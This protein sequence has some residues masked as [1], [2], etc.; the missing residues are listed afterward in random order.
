[1]NIPVNPAANTEQNKAGAKENDDVQPIILS[2]LTGRDTEVDLLLDRWEQ[3]REGMGQVVLITG[4]A[5]LGKSRLVATIKQTVL[6]ESGCSSNDEESPARRYSSPVIEWRCSERFQSTGL[7]PFANCLQ[8]LLAFTSVETTES[9]FDRLAQY[10][11]ECGL[12]RREVVALFAKLLFLP[13]DERFSTGG[14]S[15]VRERE[16]TFRA[17]REWLKACS[18]RRPILFVIEDLHWFDASSLEF[19]QQ[20]VAEG[21]HESILTVL[22]FR[23]EFKTPW[24]ALAHQTSL[25]LNRLTRRQFAELMRKSAGGALPD[26]LM[27]QIYQRT[28]GVPLLV[29]E[30]TRMARESAIFDP[31]RGREMPATLQQLLMARLDRISSNREVAHFAAT[32]GREF[33]YE[34]L[35]AVV[36]VDEP[37]LQAELAKLAGAEILFSKGEPPRCAYLFK[38]ALLEEALR[39]ALESAQRR[40]FH[41]QVAEVMEA[42]FPQAAATQPELLALHFTEAGMVEK[43]VGYWLQAGRRS[44]ERFANE[45]A[46]RQLS[47]GMELLNSTAETPARH[48]RELELLGPLGTA[49]IAARGYAAP[50]VGPIFA[51]ARTLSER[52]GAT[53]QTF[54]ML[55]GH[56]AFHVVRGD[57]VLCTELADEAMKLAGRMKDPGMLMEALFL[58]ALSYLYRGNFADAYESCAMALVQYDDRSRTAFWASLTGEDSGVAH[59]CYRALASWHLGF[60]D[61]A[62]TLMRE[63]KDLARS[64]HH[65]FS[66]EYALHHCGWLFQHCRLGIE[67]QTSGDEEMRIATEQGFL[68]WHASGMLFSGAGL[69]L[70]GRLEEG[71]RL[72]QKGL[73]AYR[74]TG[75]RLGLTYY[76]SI[77]GES[78][79][80]MGRFE[81]ARRTF[82]EALAL[83]E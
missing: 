2:P 30:F 62:L 64:I 7:Y 82:E 38:H 6:E 31:L 39:N 70:R 26:S 51:R 3:A 72:F 19:L 75:A 45:E 18:V 40:Q 65:P 67:T 77:L 81:D 14:L 43:A 13:S 27:A 20:F 22:T 37:T 32:L 54:V 76:F 4:E 1:M 16:E 47:R 48:D 66:L 23:P 46:I 50:E 33:D 52:L 71:Q 57:F 36:S 69:L 12:G 78:F 10:L 56:F 34:L 42:R 74:G 73:E 21:L 53:Q 5:G 28:G 24:P 83:V 55:R 8:Q 9:R 49:W 44:L 60:P 35:A 41:Q 68:F 61:R 58:Q 29:E 80:L 11:D 59:R 63:A 15:P 17:V 25:A 79:Q